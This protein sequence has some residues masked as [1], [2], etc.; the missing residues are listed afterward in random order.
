MGKLLKSNVL[1]GAS[2]L[3]LLTSCG[4][5]MNGYSETDGAYYD[6]RRDTVPQYDTRTAGNQVGGYYSYG[7][8]E[9]ESYD[10]SIVRQ[11]QYNQKKQQTKYQNWGNKKQIPIGETLPEHKPIIPTIAFMAVGGILMVGVDGD[12]RSTDHTMVEV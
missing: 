11:S 7:D 12:L 8:D 4:A 5:Y 9:D 2:A 10:T 1:L 3:G 6:P